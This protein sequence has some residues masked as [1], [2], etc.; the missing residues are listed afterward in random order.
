M[1]FYFFGIH[2][3]W[4][5]VLKSSS[6]GSSIKQHL[7]WFINIVFFKSDSII[8]WPFQGSR[9][10]KFHWQMRLPFW[11]QLWHGQMFMQNRADTFF[12]IFKVSVIFFTLVF[13]K[14]FRWSLLC[15]PV[16]PPR[17]FGIIGV[18]TTVLKVN[19]PFLYH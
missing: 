6:I 1:L 15:F 2:V 5:W 7:T 9:S 4:L 19:Q 10:K 14:T 17:L 13:A 3:V 11:K 16:L 18:C 12:N 8:V